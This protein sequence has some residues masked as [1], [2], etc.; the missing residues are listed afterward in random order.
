VGNFASVPRPVTGA[1]YRRSVDVFSDVIGSLRTGQAKFARTRHLGR[2]GNRFGPHRGAG[3]HVVLA[4]SCWLVPETGDPIRLAAGDVVLLPHGAV[5]GLTDDPRRSLDRLPPESDGPDGGDGDLRTGSATLLCGAYRLDHGQAHPFLRAL[6]Q[7]IHL[8]A[9]ADRP[10]ALRSA[11]EL[12]TA[13]LAE[14]QPG[15]DAA[16]PALLDLLL[17][18]ALRAW[19]EQES[20]RQPGAGWHAA[21]G[22]PGVAAALRAVHREPQAPWTVERLAAL[23]GLSRTTFARR[24]TATMGLPPLAYLT[25]WRL[26]RAA[27]LLAS[28]DAALATIARR[29]GYTSEFAFANAFKREFGI[30]PGRYRRQ[31]R[32]QPVRHE[33]DLSPGDAFG[34]A[35]DHAAGGSSGR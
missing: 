1:S 30:S 19:S 18:Y 16:L 3:F 10:A 8:P 27:Q 7:V 29:V 31:Q 34:Q 25:W 21:L 2:W 9:T 6:P 20:R 22:D 12:L 13:D 23:S 15:A 28:G 4:G 14:P 33:F 35:D 32:E 24:F 26:S 17:V 11:V 5:H